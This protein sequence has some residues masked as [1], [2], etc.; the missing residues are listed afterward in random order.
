MSHKFNIQQ[1]RCWKTKKYSI[2]VN[3]TLG[4]V[5]YTSDKERKNQLYDQLKIVEKFVIWSFVLLVK[6]QHDSLIGFF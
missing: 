2:I 5:S 1:I 4:N 3:K 6:Q